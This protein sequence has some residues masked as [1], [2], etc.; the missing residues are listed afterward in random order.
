MEQIITVETIVNSDI[1]KVW[2]YWT[3]PEHIVNWNFASADWECPSATNELQMGGV[4]HYMMAAKDGSASFDF[5][6]LYTNVVPQSLIEYTIEDGRK[7]SVSLNEED[8]GVRVVETFEMEHENP[9]DMQQAGWQAILDNFKGYV[10][11]N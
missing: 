2:D 11:E 7:V 10:E 3:K 8:G 5:N 9:R 6:G 1:G 4:F